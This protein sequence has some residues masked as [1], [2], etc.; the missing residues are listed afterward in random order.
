MRKEERKRCILPAQMLLPAHM[1]ELYTDTEHDT[2]AEDDAP[3]KAHA[4]TW[5]GCTRSFN[6]PWRLKDHICSHT[7]EVWRI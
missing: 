2:D 6:K 3:A 5:E 1:A 4:C 7:G